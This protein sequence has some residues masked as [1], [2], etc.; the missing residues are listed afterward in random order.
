[1]HTCTR[2]LKFVRVPVHVKS[3]SSGLGGGGCWRGGHGGTLMK[4]RHL[5]M[6]DEDTR[7]D[8]IAKWARGHINNNRN[9]ATRNCGMSVLQR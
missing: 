6:L 7:I 2:D 8:L 5:E 9:V 4:R 1:V 3:V